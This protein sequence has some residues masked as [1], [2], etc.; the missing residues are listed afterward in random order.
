[1]YR[2]RSDVEDV[3]HRG[4]VVSEV[5]WLAKTH[6]NWAYDLLGIIGLSK[7]LVTGIGSR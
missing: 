5:D 1:M 7:E 6:L 2:H 4:I 3:D